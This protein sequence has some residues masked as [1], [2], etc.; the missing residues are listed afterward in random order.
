MK[1]HKKNWYDRN[2]L[3]IAAIWVFLI[4]VGAL[5][6]LVDAG[7]APAASKYPE[8]F[9]SSVK[10]DST[11]QTAQLRSAIARAATN[12]GMVKLDSGVV[13]LTDTIYSNVTI[14][15]NNTRI[16]FVGSATGFVGGSNS[17]FIGLDVEW[18]GSATGD[19][20]RGAAITFGSRTSGVKV[21]N[22]IV[23]KCTFKTNRQGGA[24]ICVAGNSDVTIRNCVVESNGDSTR[25]GILAKYAEDGND[26][27]YHPNVTIE[28][29]A[30]DTLTPA[31]TNGYS[32]SL[33]GVYQAIVKNVRTHYSYLGAD[34]RP[35]SF[36]FTHAHSGNGFGP[37]SYPSVE[38]INCHFRD[39]WTWGARV[40]GSV[41][42]TTT[43]TATLPV[44]FENCTFSGHD[45]TSGSGYNGQDPT[46]AMMRYVAR[47]VKFSHCTFYGFTKGFSMDEA[48]GVVFDGCLFEGNQYGPF[49]NSS[50]LPDNIAVQNCKIQNISAAGEYGIYVGRARNVILQGN[51]IGADGDQ[52]IKYGIAIRDDQNTAKVKLLGNHVV[53]LLDDVNAQAF[54]ID[55]LGSIQ[56]WA[57]NTIDTSNIPV[58]RYSQNTNFSG[59]WKPMEFLG[60][61]RPDS[62]SSFADGYLLGLVVNGTDTTWTMVSPGAGSTDSALVLQYSGGHISDSLAQALLLSGGT[63]TG[64]IDLTGVNATSA[65]TVSASYFIPIYLSALVGG[66]IGILSNLLA[67]GDTV[68]ARGFES[69][70]GDTLKVNATNGKIYLDGSNNMVF[71]DGVTS[72]K[73]LA[74][75]VAGG[76]AAVSDSSIAL[77]N[78]TAWRLFYSNAT[79]TAIQ[80]LALGAS[81][82]YLRSNGASSAPTWATPAGGSGVWDTLSTKDTLVY[83]GLTND[84]TYIATFGNDSLKIWHSSGT[85]VIGNGGGPFTT[86]TVVVNNYL[87]ADSIATVHLTVNGVPLDADTSIL[88]EGEAATLY[89][90][91]ADTGAYTATLQGLMSDSTDLALRLADTAAYSTTLKGDMSDTGDVVRSEIRDT[92]EA[93]VD[94]VEK[95]FTI[96]AP[97]GVSDTI[98]LFYVNPAI[99]PSGVT[100][101]RLD[102]YTG[103]STGTY[104]LEF[105]EWETNGLTAR[106]GY[107]DTLTIANDSAHIHSTTFTDASIAANGSIWAIV[108]A[109]DVD[110]IAGSIVFTKD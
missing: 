3:K 74:E 76:N 66:D 61:R 28:N 94:T 40:S 79:T 38:I 75:L 21:D 48:D 47:S 9:S 77:L 32:I 104:A 82:T 95:G 41:W 6:K 100:L 90:A 86:D 109:T 27:T 18:S 68:N 26:S 19:E 13:L 63:M 51:Q 22:A 7:T 108:P 103:D 83:V 91:I 17:K 97:D 14:E 84:T 98:S 10:T 34:V 57:N 16:S 71:V 45:T 89:L 43:D 101:I 72:A 24:A 65:D 50:S 39:V 8:T 55:T 81:G 70:E 80:E 53:D 96:F 106:A 1:S 85:I 102:L 88:S 4:A 30:I 12:S 15:G 36:G 58:A 29:V 33:D 35:D 5:V 64:D 73:T 54:R 44:L 59:G 46:G 78:A 69:I 11:D 105:E 62:S 99:Y 107:I 23:E 67:L 92:I 93:V 31:D 25:F 52:S 56:A 49:I 110:W 2:F 42:G 37:S 87:T 20:T 60:Y